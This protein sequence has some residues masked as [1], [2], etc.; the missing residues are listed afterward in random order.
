MRKAEAIACGELSGHHY[1][2]DFSYCDSGML[3]WL[4]IWELLSSKNVNLSGLVASRK[5]QF[6]SSGEINFEVSDP[7]LCI[8]E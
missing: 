4:L 8:Q 2:R 3:P 6:P 1:F 5:K 7:E